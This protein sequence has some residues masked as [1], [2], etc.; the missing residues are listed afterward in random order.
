MLGKF[1]DERL[2]NDRIMTRYSLQEPLSTLIH[3]LTE[4]I[5]T[6]LIDFNILD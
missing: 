6:I 2:D 1:V 3:F 4:R 5:L